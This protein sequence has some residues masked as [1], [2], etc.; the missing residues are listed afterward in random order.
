MTFARRGVAVV[1][2]AANLVIDPGHLVAGR[3]VADAVRGVEADQV[4]MAP[5]LSQSCP[6]G[7]LVS[8]FDR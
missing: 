2:A 4:L 5:G 8:V 7:A 6:T 3:A 1:L